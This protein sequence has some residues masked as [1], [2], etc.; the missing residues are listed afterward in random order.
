MKI[1][2]FLATCPPWDLSFEK[3][4]LVVRRIGQLDQINE[5]IIPTI[6]RGE[7]CPTITAHV[8]EVFEHRVDP[9]KAVLEA[10]RHTLP[11]A[12][13]SVSKALNKDMFFEVPATENLR[14][15]GAFVPLDDILSIGVPMVYGSLEMVTHDCLQ[16]FSAHEQQRAKRVQR[17]VREITVKKFGKLL[18]AQARMRRSHTSRIIDLNTNTLH[19]YELWAAQTVLNHFQSVHTAERRKHSSKARYASAA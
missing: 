1:H 18:S 12:F 5:A 14:A 4:C 8:P 6:R 10:V 3:V 2:L 16:E 13:K 7:M 15:F 19:G 17:Q 9:R 11:D